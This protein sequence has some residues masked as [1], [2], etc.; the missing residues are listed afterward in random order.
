MSI[1]KVDTINEKTSGNGVQIAGHVLQVQQGVMT[2]RVQVTT[3]SEYTI[4]DGFTVN[5]TPSSTSSK[6]L[7]MPMLTSIVRTNALINLYI[8]RDSTK[9]TTLGWYHG[10]TNWGS[11][12]MGG[13]FLDSPS[14]TSQITYSCRYKVANVGGGGGPWLNYNS[15]SMG[16]TNDDGRSTITAMEIGQ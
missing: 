9:V 7:V 6:I 10:N 14:T 11:L 4:G 2:S 12:L 3:T 1:L 8:Y 5:I 16:G 13:N 15:T